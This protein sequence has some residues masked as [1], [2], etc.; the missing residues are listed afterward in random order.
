MAKLTNGNIVVTWTG[1]E[2]TAIVHYRIYDGNLTPVSGVLDV[3]RPGISNECLHPDVAA[4]TGGGFVIT[5]EGISSS[6]DTDIFAQRYSADGGAN[7]ETIWG[8]ERQP[9]YG[10]DVLPSVAGLKDGGFAITHQRTTADGSTAWHS[11]WNADGS[12]RLTD[13]TY[14]PFGTGEQADGRDRPRGDGGYMTN[15]VNDGWNTA[16]DITGGRFS[17]AGVN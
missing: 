7:G 13:R 12:V 4:L 6:T 15:H 3:V 16:M 14:V 8:Q 10:Q 9:R 17:P 1:N 11:V 5:W 2:A